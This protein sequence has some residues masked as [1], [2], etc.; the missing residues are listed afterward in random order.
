MGV[1]SPIFYFQGVKM[2]SVDELSNYDIGASKYRDMHFHDAFIVEVVLYTKN[3]KYDRKHFL[4]RE[5]FIVDEE[6][7]NRI[8]K[9]GRTA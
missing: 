8:V 4:G 3:H 2:V 9:M 1:N 5:R 6:T 7:A